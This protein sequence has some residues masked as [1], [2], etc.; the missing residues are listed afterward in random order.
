MIHPYYLDVPP[1]YDN[2]TKV[3]SI[4]YLDVMMVEANCIGLKR[5]MLYFL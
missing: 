5:L 2:K 4:I 3:I 1:T